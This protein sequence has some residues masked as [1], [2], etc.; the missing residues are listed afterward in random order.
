MESATAAALAGAQ[1][2]DG[3]L[4]GVA[5]LLRKLFRNLC[6]AHTAM[7]TSGRIVAAPRLAGSTAPCA[8]RSEEN[9]SVTR[10]RR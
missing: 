9:P 5:G 7:L 8:K 2:V 10:T 1:R 3:L 4:D 6:E